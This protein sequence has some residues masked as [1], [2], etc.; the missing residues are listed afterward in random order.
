MVQVTTMFFSSFSTVWN[1]TSAND[2]GLV[3]DGVAL[4]VDVGTIDVPT[5]YIV[6][7]YICYIP[8]LY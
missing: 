7:S 4:G 1:F 8:L 3:G 5:L 2:M 6:Y